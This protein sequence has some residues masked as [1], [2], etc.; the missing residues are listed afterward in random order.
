MSML[1]IAALP[2]FTLNLWHDIPVMLRYGFMHQAVLAGTILSLTTGL[3]GYVVVLRHQAFAG[4]SLSD[5]AFTGALGGRP[6][7]A[8]RSSA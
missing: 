5:G 4:A 8:T 7:A 3:V 2:P 1:V 6:W